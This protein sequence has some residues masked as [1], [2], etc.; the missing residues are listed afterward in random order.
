MNQRVLVFVEA[1]GC[2]C[3]ACRFDEAS[4]CGLS[5]SSGF[6]SIAD[7]GFGT[8]CHHHLHFRPDTLLV[9]CID[10]WG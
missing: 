10:F 9:R 3:L 5:A 7:L 6:H 2:G 1:G 4:S 8:A